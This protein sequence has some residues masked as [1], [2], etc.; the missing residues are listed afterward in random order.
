MRKELAMAQVKV[1]FTI[2][3]WVDGDPPERVNLCV[4]AIEALGVAVE[5]GPFGTSFVAP[6]EVASSALASVVSIAYANGATHVSIDIE[7]VD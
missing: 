7:K 5:V 2:E 1:E 4:A 3:P 6:A